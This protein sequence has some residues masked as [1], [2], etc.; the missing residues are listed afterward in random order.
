[1]HKNIWRKHGKIPDNDADLLKLSGKPAL[2]KKNW[3]E[4]P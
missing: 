2:R 4:Q 1:M 3:Q